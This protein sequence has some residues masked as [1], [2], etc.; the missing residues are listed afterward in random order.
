MSDDGSELVTEAG[1]TA[2]LLDPATGR[3]RTGLKGVA[4]VQMGVPLSRIL[5]GD[6]AFLRNGQ[7]LAIPSRGEQSIS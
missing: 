6:V 4:K 5:Q 2:S 3:Q 1:T 7:W